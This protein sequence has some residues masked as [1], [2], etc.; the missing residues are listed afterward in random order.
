[1]RVSVE[2]R[3]ID[4]ADVVES[5]GDGAV[6]LRAD[7]HTHLFSPAAAER[8]SP[9]QPFKPV[10]A[11]DLL[12]VFD[13]DNV[14]WALV[15]SVAYFFA[16]PDLGEVDSVA[17][18]AEND[19]TAAETESHPGRLRACCSVNPVAAGAVGEIERC[20]AKG[21]FIGVK[22]HLANSDL[23]LRN[24]AHLEAIG[25]VFECANQHG[26]MLV[27][28]MRTRRPDY[29]AA[30]VNHFVEHVLPRAQ[31][32]PVQI[33]HAAGW[34]GYDSV[35]G[36][37]FE[38]FADWMTARPADAANLHFDI[39]LTPIEHEP[40]DE[41]TIPSAS[42]E[43]PWHGRRYAHLAEQIRRVGPDKVV[44]GTDWPV[45]QPARYLAEMREHLPLEPDT[46]ERIL[47]ATTINDLD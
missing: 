17:L 23:D 11:S 30:D 19:W 36:S 12:R 38:A 7:H 15:L 31:S 13:R 4:E 41:D 20:A 34:G 43:E 39:A 32:V 33:A 44:F 21:T 22:L 37:A 27:V 25:D 40:D 46:F 16:M 42:G 29:G 28:H 24:D 14:G 26:L 2:G 10:H 8:I 47:R 1:M 45:A 3:G 35:T 18:S 6:R 9:V 5:R